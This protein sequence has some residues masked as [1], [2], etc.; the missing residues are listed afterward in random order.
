MFGWFHALFQRR[1]KRVNAPAVPRSHATDLTEH[2]RRV[3]VQRHESA[4]DVG[5]MHWT[6]CHAS[7]RY[8]FKAEMT[9]PQGHGLTLRSHRVN[10]S[11][12][13]WPSVICPMPGCTFHEFVQ[14]DGW[15]FGEVPSMMEGGGGLDPRE[16]P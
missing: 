9:C 16:K 8:R 7:T 12:A 1:P 3:H 4:G 15:S 5:P 14:L 2:R 11:G 6:P 10:R 13:V